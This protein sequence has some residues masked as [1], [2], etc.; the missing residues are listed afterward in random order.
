M[1]MNTFLMS[2]WVL[3]ISSIVSLI[4]SDLE[5]DYNLKREQTDDLLICP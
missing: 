2:C 5:L 1:N 4:I 3:K